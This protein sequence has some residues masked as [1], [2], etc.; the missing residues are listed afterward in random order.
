MKEESRFSQKEFHNFCKLIKIKSSIGDQI[1]KVVKENKNEEGQLSVCE[2]FMSMHLIVLF[3]KERIKEIPKELPFHLKSF[4]QKFEDSSSAKPTRAMQSKTVKLTELQREDKGVKNLTD[5]TEI[6][7]QLLNQS[8]LHFENEDRDRQKALQQKDEEIR[9]IS[10]MIAFFDGE[11]NEMRK[12]NKK[13]DETIA[14]IKKIVQIEIPN[15]INSNTEKWREEINNLKDKNKQ[16]VSE[17][18]QEVKREVKSVE[19]MAKKLNQQ[20]ENLKKHEERV[21]MINISKLFKANDISEIVNVALKRKVNDDF[22]SECKPDSQEIKVR[23]I[24]HLEQFAHNQ[25]NSLTNVKCNEKIATDEESLKNIEDPFEI[26]DEASVENIVQEVPVEVENVEP[27]LQTTPNTA[28]S[29]KTQKLEVLD[30]NTVENREAVQVNETS[31]IDFVDPADP[32]LQMTN[33]DTIKSQKSV[34]PTKDEKEETLDLEA[35]N[36]IMKIEFQNKEEVKETPKAAIDIESSFE[37]KNNKSL[38][39]ESDIEVKKEKD[40]IDETQDTVQ[41]SNKKDSNIFKES[42]PLISKNDISESENESESDED[43]L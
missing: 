38:T 36:N 4:K 29:V 37:S 11:V 41:D 40:I 18:I 3:L 10:D 19:I 17:L 13:L 43:E 25:Q 35:K 23:E 34:S 21:E 8:N 2:S 7:N 9:L 33:E 1:W 5:E 32:F 39:L 42:Q 26:Q 6:L 20:R 12:E 28:E 31:N 30:K 24:V 16:G 15:K 14:L 27:S 22:E